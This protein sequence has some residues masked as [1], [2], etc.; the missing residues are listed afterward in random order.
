RAREAG[1]PFHDSETWRNIGTL[2]R[3]MGR[4]EEARAALE[5]AIRG[6]IYADSNRHNSEE[7]LEAL[8]RDV[9]WSVGRPIPSFSARDLEGHP[10][11]PERYRGQVLL[12]DLWSTWDEK[13]R[14]DLPT[15]KALHDQYHGQGL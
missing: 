10:Q 9:A 1:Q 3:Q 2:L 6:A 7:A 12:I 15:L 8:K 4:K 14:A 13:T 11:S 5:E